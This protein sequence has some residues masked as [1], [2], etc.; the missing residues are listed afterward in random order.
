[1][2][3]IFFLICVFYSIS[4]LYSQNITLDELISLR[5]KDLAEIEEFV[6]NKN[7]AFLSA[8]E[9]TDDKMGKAIFTFNKSIY[10]DSAECFLTYL[11]SDTRTRLNLQF[12]NK[13]QYNRYISRLKT[14]GSQ[15]ILSKVKAN[16]IIKTYQIAK[17]IIQVTISSK[18]ENNISE[19]SYAI[20]IITNEDYNANFLEE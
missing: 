7:W 2:K 13:D 16:R 5:K 8:N 6:S 3:K 12:I 11:Y 15:L 20:F 4:N 1:M 17:T 14:L 10:N 18:N 9:I 19:I